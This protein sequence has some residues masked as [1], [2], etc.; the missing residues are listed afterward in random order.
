MKGLL[1]AIAYMIPPLFFSLH[2]SISSSMC[3][4]I[5]FY[6]MILYALWKGW[7]RLERKIAVPVCAFAA[8]IL[9]ILSAVFSISLVQQ[10]IRRCALLHSL[11]RN[12]IVRVQVIS[13]IYLERYF[14]NADGL[15]APEE[16]DLY[17]VSLHLEENG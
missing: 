8:F 14:L 15:A 7:F 10:I 6:G 12:Q 9:P 13:I 16:K 17:R 5:V 1:R 2:S 4:W 3:I 11:I